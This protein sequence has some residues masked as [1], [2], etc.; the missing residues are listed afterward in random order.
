M[1]S[2]IAMLALMG[3]NLAALNLELE[4]YL[5]PALYG[6]DL[7]R[8]LTVNNILFPSFFERLLFIGLDIYFFC[9]HFLKYYY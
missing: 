2:S 9:L 5:L 1:L 4:I 3:K 7:V 8:V 6:V